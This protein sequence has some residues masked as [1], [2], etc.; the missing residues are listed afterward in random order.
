M[1][2]YG[3]ED[4]DVNQIA[5]PR[6]KRKLLASTTATHVSASALLPP[7]PVRK[8]RRPDFSRV[9][10]TPSEDE[11]DNFEADETFDGENEPLRRKKNRRKIQCKINTN[12]P[13]ELKSNK[14]HQPKRSHPSLNVPTYSQFNSHLTV[15]EDALALLKYA[16]WQARTSFLR[17][18]G[19]SGLPRSETNFYRY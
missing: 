17:E 3:K 19:G 13:P 18:K 9:K 14:G 7:K 5:P 8:K 11:G 10:E 4:S 2:I 15:M 1:N 12:N 16:C 6:K